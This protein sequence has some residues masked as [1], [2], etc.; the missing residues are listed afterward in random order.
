[1][2]VCVCVCV[3]KDTFCLYNLTKI[4]SSSK[5]ELVG[6]FAIYIYI[7]REREREREACGVMN[8]VIRNGDGDPSSKPGQGC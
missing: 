5:L 2:C 7:Y 8:I 6:E 4:L 1:M 3:Y